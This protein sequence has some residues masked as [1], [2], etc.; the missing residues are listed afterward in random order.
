MDPHATV[1]AL[2]ANDAALADG[3]ITQ[4]QHRESRDELLAILREW[5]RKGG[6]APRGGWPKGV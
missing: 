5:R 2:A 4:S 6:F 1:R 3:E